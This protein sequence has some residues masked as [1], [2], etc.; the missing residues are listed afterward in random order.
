MFV[1]KTSMQNPVKSFGYIKCYSSNS[2]RPVK[3]LTILSGTTV[4]R[5]AVDREDLKP[6]WNHKKGHISGGDQQSYQQDFTNH[7]KK[8]NR[9]VVFSCRPLQ[10]F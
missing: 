5:S 8:T 9:V 4:R 2:A 10:T 6:Y 7:R 3:T 1:K